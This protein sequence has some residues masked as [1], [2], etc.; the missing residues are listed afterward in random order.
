ML[1]DF[2]EYTMRMK[3]CLPQ[4]HI[5]MCCTTYCTPLFILCMIYFCFPA[6]YSGL[7]TLPSIHLYHPLLPSPF[8]TI[9]PYLN[10]RT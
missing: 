8:N 1:Y 4:V 3:G 5:T 6:L 7:C 9:Y 10:P 2:Y